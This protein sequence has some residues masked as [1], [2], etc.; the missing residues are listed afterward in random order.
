MSQINRRLEYQLQLGFLWLNKSPT[1]VGTL[2]TSYSTWNHL[3]LREW[4]HQDAGHKL[5]QSGVRVLM[6]K[7]IE[8]G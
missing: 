2:Y 4:L 6:P 1:E 5:V 7:L 8:V 3:W